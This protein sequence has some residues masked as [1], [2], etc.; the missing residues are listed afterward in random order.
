MTMTGRVKSALDYSVFAASGGAF[1]LATARHY[2]WS[3]DEARNR[4]K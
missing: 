1:L 2:L 4:R 3:L